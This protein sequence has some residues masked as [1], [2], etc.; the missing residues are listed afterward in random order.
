MSGERHKKAFKRWFNLLPEKTKLLVAAVVEILVPELERR[1]FVW[2][3]YLYTDSGGKYIERADM[4]PM[5]RRGPGYYDVVIVGLDVK[6][7]PRFHIS[8]R[9]WTDEELARRE[10][11]L[12]HSLTKRQSERASAKEFGFSQFDPFVTETRCK[13]LVN[14][15]VALLPQMDECFARGVCGPN[16]TKSEF[17]CLIKT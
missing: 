5:Q 10:S 12:P 1:G 9:R 3:D 7:R 16:V 4:I 15:V 17:I 11:W 2:V 8:F 13:K 6:R 14:E